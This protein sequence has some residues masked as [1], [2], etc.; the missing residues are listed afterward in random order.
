MTA[1]KPICTYVPGHEP[2]ELIAYYPDQAAYYPE[3]EQQT[4][5]WFV[6]NI[7]RDWTIFDVGAN[8]GYYS[9]LFS[10]LAADGRVFAFEPTSTIGMLRQNLTHHRCRNV[11]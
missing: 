10:K 1:L 6:E 5:R 9:I 7:Q 8:I 3:C 11:T 2:I 4:K